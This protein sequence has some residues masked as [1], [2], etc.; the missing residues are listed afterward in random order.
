MCKTQVDIFTTF[1]YVLGQ[2]QISMCSKII[3]GNQAPFMTKI[4]SKAIM[5][6]SRLRS[7]YNQWQSIE[8]FLA[9]RK[10][11][12]YCKNLSKMTKKAYF[13]QMT[14]QGFVNSK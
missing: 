5:N 7:K 9:F 11:K 6:R 14:R 2:L 4:L 10:T 1:T 8:K 3:R 12:N 13:E